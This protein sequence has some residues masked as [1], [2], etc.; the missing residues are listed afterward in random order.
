MWET[1]NFSSLGLV[2]LKQLYENCQ[3]GSESKISGAPYQQPHR[4]KIMSKL[5]HYVQ[6][7]AHQIVSKSKSIPQILMHFCQTLSKCLL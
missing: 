7:S 4:E 6:E 3:R 1:T 2:N 5:K